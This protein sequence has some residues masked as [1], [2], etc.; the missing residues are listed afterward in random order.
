MNLWY[1]IAHILGKIPKSYILSF[2]VFPFMY[3]FL[4][5]SN[6][7]ETD[8]ESARYLLSALIQ[9]EAAIIAVVVTISLV[10]VQLTSSHYSQRVI[11]QVTENIHISLLVVSCL[12]SII[13]SI[14]VLK[15]I[16][17][18]DGLGTQVDINFASSLGVW[19]FFLVLFCVNETLS[20]ISPSGMV[21]NLS[22]KIARN[23]FL[24]RNSPLDEACRI[25]RDSKKRMDYQDMKLSLRILGEEIHNMFKRESLNST[26]EEIIS[27]KIAFGVR[28]I[29]FP[30]TRYSRFSSE[31]FEFFSE[32]V[33]GAIEEELEIVSKRLMALQQEIIIYSLENSKWE[34]VEFEI[35][36]LKSILETADRKDSFESAKRVISILRNV[37]L[38]VEKEKTVGPQSLIVE[39]IKH[40]LTGIEEIAENDEIRNFAAA[41]CKEIFSQEESGSS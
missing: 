9:S 6:S 10:A 33:K 39:K 15:S 4:H 25:I 35:E 30:G 13:Y 2:A 8:K 36:E 34:E 3:F 18:C 7:W 27:K 20:M 24:E 26:E 19:C 37:A 38:S 22:R 40:T 11:D 1:H 5:Y 16:G 23:S 32:V 21:L 31:I 12:F 28:R 17:R 41:T 29:S 14:S